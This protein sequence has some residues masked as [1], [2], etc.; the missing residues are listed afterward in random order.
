MLFPTP[1]PQIAGG[2][3]WAKVSLGIFTILKDSG[4]SSLVTVIINEPFS[5]EFFCDSI[6]IFSKFFPAEFAQADW[7][8]TTQPRLCS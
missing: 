8:G 4:F 1:P 5:E 7:D 3:M 6:G 2:K